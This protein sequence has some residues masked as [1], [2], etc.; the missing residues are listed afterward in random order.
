M[1]SQ[2]QSKNVNK[3][4]MDSDSFLRLFI[5]SLKIQ[6]PMS[7]METTDMMAQLTQ[8]TMIETMNNMKNAVDSMINQNSLSNPIGN[9]IDLIGKKVKIEVD[10]QVEEGLVI[11]VGKQGDDVMFELENE[12]V[13]NVNDIVGVTTYI[14]ESNSENNVIENN[15]NEIDVE[16][17]QTIDNEASE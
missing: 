3:N 4:E 8:F 17:N 12:K 11:S 9:Y 16:E 15:T 14:S 13:F 2:T 7:P 10:G 1:Q 5:E 6:D